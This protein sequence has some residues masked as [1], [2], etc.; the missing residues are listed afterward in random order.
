MITATKIQQ[1]LDKIFRFFFRVFF[2]LLIVAIPLIWVIQDDPRVQLFAKQKLIEI[3]QKEWK[4]KIE[5]ESCNI[6]LFTGNIKIKNGVIKD[7]RFP[8]DCWWR[9]ESANVSLSRLNYLIEKKLTL[10]I[11][12]NN[13]TGKTSFRDGKFAIQDHLKEVF[14]PSQEFVVDL[15]N[16]SLNNIDLAVENKNLDSKLPK[17][18]TIKVDGTLAFEK[19]QKNQDMI[20][21]G[22]Y[23]DIKN[24]TISCDNKIFVQN[25]KG[26]NNFEQNELWGWTIKLDQIFMFPFISPQDSFLIKGKIDN[27]KSDCNL[28]DQCKNLELNFTSTWDYQFTALGCA[29]VDLINK[30][31]KFFTEKIYLDKQIVGCCNF[32]LK[33]DYLKDFKS[34]GKIGLQ[35]LLVNNVV[36]GSA[37]LSFSQDAK[38]IEGQFDLDFVDKKFLE[39]N[40]KLSGEGIFYFENQV[41]KFFIKNNEQVSIFKDYITVNPEKFQLVFD[42]DK[43]LNCAGKYELAV[44]SNQVD[45]NNRNHYDLRGDCSLKNKNLEIYGNNKTGKYLLQCILSPKFYLTKIFYEDKGER[46]IDASADLYILHGKAKYSFLRT[47][48]PSSIKRNVLGKAAFL[49]FSL[50]QENYDSLKG[51]IQLCGGNL[52]AFDVYNPIKN[53]KLDFQADTKAKKLFFKNLKLDFFKGR[54]S[55]P[56]VSLTFKDDY[57]TDF[58]HAPLLIEDFLINFKK[59]FY[60]I[61]YGNLVFSNNTLSDRPQENF[62]KLFGDLVLKRSLFKENMF[63]NGSQGNI[64]S[65]IVPTNSA[66]SGDQVVQFDI[67][68]SSEKPMVVK[69][70][71]VQS[72]ANLELNLKSMYFNNRLQTPLVA[73]SVD[74]QKG[75]LNFLHHKLFINYGKIQFLP[76]QRSDPLIDL[77]AQNR[78]KKYLVSLQ[79]SGS[80][81]NPNIVLESS[82]ELSEE[83]ILSLLFAGSENV[84]FQADLP[85]VFMQN[86]NNLIM[87]SQDIFPKGSALFKKL[88]LPFKYVQITPDFANQTGYG[89]I[90]GTVSVD[91]N[92]QIH[93]QIQKN[94]NLQEDFTFQVEYFLT[95]DINLK[96][97]RDQSGEIGSEVEFRLKF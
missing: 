26:L 57:S 16:V 71:F 9:F 22:G 30:F 96:V 97:L 67:N 58:I 41:G 85:Q 18:F 27:G 75:S 36:V 44:S 92:D 11:F 74:L 21:W 39:Q 59:S 70:S 7:A 88:T 89:G 81:Q 35:N 87:G 17:N 42:I 47:F 25:I 32:D 68:L 13:V 86:L 93:A 79:V 40:L 84:S 33:V 69:T 80:L 28:S 1:I 3:L 50:D 77:V 46:V 62:F 94:F 82:P 52:T 60:G 65:E 73:G 64:F 38:K 8:D 54:I 5:L 15:R 91:L 4:A 53:A 45:K 29:Q 14:I 49:S 66:I 20:R 23:F 19:R 76:N 51:S 78:I 12:F 55:S 56:E 24:G 61:V 95:D 43:E 10:T 2:A 83:Q 6:N 63:S 37:D 72:N 31:Y 90:K 34:S 48:L